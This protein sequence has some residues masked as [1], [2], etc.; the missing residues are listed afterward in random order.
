M[1]TGNFSGHLSR[2]LLCFNRIPDQ[3]RS[4]FWGRIFDGRLPP[5]GIALPGVRSGT[6][7]EQA[8]RH[9]GGLLVGAVI[10]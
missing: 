4:S 6:N 8:L 3:T 10:S 5:R 2:S 1:R 9:A 7:D